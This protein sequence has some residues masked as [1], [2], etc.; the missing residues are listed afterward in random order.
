MPTGSAQHPRWRHRVVQE[1]LDEGV[2]CRHGLVRNIHAKRCF[3]G[4]AKC[5]K[6]LGDTIVTKERCLDHVDHFIKGYDCAILAY[7]H[8]GSGK[9]FT[10]VGDRAALEKTTANK[11]TVD[12]GSGIIPRCLQQIFDACDIIE[13]A[14][15]VVHLSCSYMEIVNERVYDLLAIP[16][17]ASPPR[18]R[19]DPPSSPSS[20]SS[21]SRLSQSPPK[22]A[23]SSPHNSL[24]NTPRSLWNS[25]RAARESL[26]LPLRQH[27][28]GHVFVQGLKQCS[29]SCGQDALELHHKA[30][31]HRSTDVP[32]G[33]TIFEI[34]M[35]RQT[36]AGTR[37]SR[38]VLVDLAGFE[39]GSHNNK[40]I[41]ALTYCMHVVSKSQHHPGSVSCVPFRESVLTRLLQPFLL[42]SSG[43]TFVVTL[44][45]AAEAI[46][47][48]RATLRFAERLRSISCK[49][50]R[51]PLVPNTAPTP[52]EELHAM[53]LE[54]N[55]LRDALARVTCK[56]E[57]ARRHDQ[58]LLMENQQLRAHLDASRSVPKQTDSPTPS[59][60]VIVD[61]ASNDVELPIKTTKTKRDRQSA[62]E[63]SSS[64]DPPKRV[65]ESS[66][67][68]TLLPRL[69]PAK[70]STARVP[71]TSLSPDLLK[72]LVQVPLPLRLQE[73][74]RPAA[75]S[76]TT[77][78]QT[79]PTPSDLAPSP[80]RPRHDPPLHN[81]TSSK[82]SSSGRSAAST[83][84]T[85]LLPSI[86]CKQ[87]SRPPHAPSATRHSRTHKKE[88]RGDSSSVM[89]MSTPRAMALPKL[90]Q[91]SPPIQSPQPSA[92]R[93]D[94]SLAQYKLRRREELET[95]LG[96]DFL[97][98]RDAF[99]FF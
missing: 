34:S 60:L 65:D 66:D 81:N 85:S 20:S 70:V 99:I 41:A 68:L 39:N 29:I 69:S 62:R 67:K 79:T 7:G 58:A 86:D 33:H 95:M 88:W 55:R 44:S 3:R 10:M 77:Y 48:T 76:T 82:A 52:I 91:R 5:V 74:R 15:D 89:V 26:G 75:P 94:D 8:T 18:P 51:Q 9:T 80:P 21:P 84:A 93:E 27:P 71:E 22:A 16:P 30:F 25:H 96:G 49:P 57:A 53:Q 17:A 72:K 23:P 92:P 32:V 19:A 43:T 42:G 36:V 98:T 12:N 4:S 31:V 1:R 97:G 11:I 90:D 38:L 14:D 83:K 37:V 28:L 59:P 6:R 56:H 40:S 63:P 73:S 45:P 47:D 35:T 46:D 13:N 64:S 61:S 87:P 2:E 24:Q 78:N 50:T 54:M